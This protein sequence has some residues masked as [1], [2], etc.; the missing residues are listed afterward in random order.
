MH[1]RVYVCWHVC[2]GVCMWKPEDKLE[3]IGSLWTMW[4]PGLKRRS[5]GLVVNSVPTQSSWHSWFILYINDVVCMCTVLD[6]SPIWSAR[7]WCLLYSESHHNQLLAHLHYLR[8]TPHAPRATTCCSGP[9]SRLSAINLFSVP[10]DSP[11]H[12]IDVLLWQT[13]FKCVFRVLYITAPSSFLSI[14]K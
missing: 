9:L 10:E 1:V 11:C 5:L 12:A 2:H 14:A 8:K 4:V 3:G 6:N 7:E 13:S